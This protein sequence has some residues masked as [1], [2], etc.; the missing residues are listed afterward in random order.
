MYSV[1][2]CLYHSSALQAT[3]LHMI[4]GHSEV[5]LRAIPLHK[6]Q[7]RV[8]VQSTDGFRAAVRAVYRYDNSQSVL[9]ALISSAIQLSRP[10]FTDS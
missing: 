9:E 5:T 2:R 7:P 8:T 1:L 4:R 10:I 6:D 3:E